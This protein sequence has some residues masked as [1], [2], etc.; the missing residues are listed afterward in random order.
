MIR[1]IAIDDE[2]LALKQ[3]ASYINRTP[4]LQLVKQCKSAAIAIETLQ[5]EEIDLMFVDINMPDITGL[6]LVKSLEKPVMTIFTTAYS[7][8][9][10]EG[11]KVD[12]VDY[13]LKPFSYEEFLKSAMRVRARW[14]LTK[15]TAPPAQPVTANNDNNYT[16]IKVNSRRMVKIDL[17]DIIYAEGQGEYVKFFI[18]NDSD[19]MLFMTMTLLEQQLPTERFMRVH[20]SYI[21]NLDHIAEISYNRIILSNGAKIPIGDLYRENFLEFINKNTLKR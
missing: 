19:Q 12:A 14:E 2:P 4:F 9:A 6:E 5:N 13:L 7:E 11:F 10:I 16:F 1:C 20:R 18:N 15:Q 21:I 8:Y 3:I 17:S